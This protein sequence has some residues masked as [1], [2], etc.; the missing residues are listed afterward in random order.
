MTVWCAYNR[1][2]TCNCIE[3]YTRQ[4]SIDWRQCCFC[5]V[6]KYRVFMCIFEVHLVYKLTL[7]IN[8]FPKHKQYFSLVG[9]KIL[10]RNLPI[11]RFSSLYDLSYEDF[12]VFVHNKHHFFHP[13]IFYLIFTDGKINHLHV[14]GCMMQEISHV[15]WNN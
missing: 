15:I 1:E 7:W 12:S 13:G 9:R 11:Y 3:H 5:E 6:W 4:I 10:F 8:V 2:R 14:S